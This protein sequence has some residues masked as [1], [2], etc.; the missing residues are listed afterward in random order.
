LNTSAGGA[1]NEWNSDVQKPLLK[2]ALATSRHA[3]VLSLHSV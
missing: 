1:E 3:K 2:L